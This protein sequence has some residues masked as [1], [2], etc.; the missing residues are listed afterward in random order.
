MRGVWKA[1]EAGVRGC[2]ATVSVLRDLHFD[3]SAGEIVGVVAAAASGKT[4]LLMCAGG[5]LRPDRGTVA[6]FGGPAR[7]DCSSRP[8]GIAYAGDRPF[9]YGFLTIREALEYAAIV[10]DLP[11]RDGA[12]RVARALDHTGLA[13]F[14]HRR[15][16]AVDG[17]ALARL[18]LAT[19][20]L[21]RPRLLLVD[22][23]PPGANADTT[24]ELL[25]VLRGVASD[26]A[27]VVIAGRL[28]ARLAALE[29]VNSAVRTRFLTLA[30]GRLESGTERPSVAARRAAAALPN[31]APLDASQLVTRARVAEL[32]PPSTARE[33][34]AH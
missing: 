32:P 27:A 3:V 17:G 34:G 26:G 11:A 18:A 30:S 8:D 9:P 22:D 24:A 31:G 15:V 28:V 10:R 20:L 29:L 2:S 33:N 25:A 13:A 5:L 14:A 7:R 1:Y 6:W 4:T 12:D 19:A 23:L 16:D 21:A